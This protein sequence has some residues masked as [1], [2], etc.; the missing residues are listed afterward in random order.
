MYLKS[1]FDFETRILIIKFDILKILLDIA[2][3][4]GVDP[5]QIFSELCSIINKEISE[6]EQRFCSIKEIHIL[7]EKELGYVYNIP[8]LIK[9][10]EKNDKSVGH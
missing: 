9:T 5:A 4:V 2:T 7:I 1:N 8:M 10:E 6:A 3:A